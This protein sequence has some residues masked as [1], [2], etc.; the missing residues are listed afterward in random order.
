MKTQRLSVGKLP[1]EDRPRERLYHVGAKGLSLQE[2]VAIVVGGG[3]REAGGIVL[4][5]RVIQ[6]FG[7]LISLGRAGVDDLLKIPGIGFARAC[8]IVAAFELGK[9]FD[10]QRLAGSSQRRHDVGFK[11]IDIDRLIRYVEFNPEAHPHGPAHLL[12]LD[13]FVGGEPIYFGFRDQALSTRSEFS[14]LPPTPPIQT[15][16]TTLYLPKTWDASLLSP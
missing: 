13:D 1:R 9:R 7:D 3:T 14:T 6:E 11:D 4:A 10:P 8:Q 12:S 2:I 15:T 5:L 16:T